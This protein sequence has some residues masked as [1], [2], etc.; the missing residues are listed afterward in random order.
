M[1]AFFEFLSQLDNIFW[2]YIAFIL[3]IILGSIL[4]YQAS[5]FQIKAFP[6]IV[7]LFASLIGS[8]S[9]QA[10]GIHPL[11]AFFASVGGMIGIGNVVG[12]VTAIQI[13]GPGALFWVW[14]AAFI[15][16]LIKY[17]E[18]FLGIKHRIPN[19]RGGYDGGPMYYLPRA[20]KN[21]SIP[22]LIS[23][24]LCIYGV[25]IYQFAVVADTLSSNFEWN[26]Y[27]VIASLL[28][29]VL[30]ASSGGISRIG[31]IC[32][33]IMPAFMITYLGMGFF[34]IFSEIWQLPEILKTVFI[35]AFTGHAA[36]GGFIGSS[37]ILAI[38]HGISRAAYSADIGIGYDSIIQS[39]TS[40]K[41]PERQARLSILGVFIDN[42][43]CTMSIMIVLMSGVWKS[44][45]PIEGSQ[46]IQTA[47]SHY[48]PYMHIFM[49]I[50]LFIVGFSTLIAYFC[51]GMKCAR[52]IS[53][54]YGVGLYMVYGATTLVAFSFLDQM[55][56]LLVM[57]VV[58]A[59]LLIT[60][61]IGIFKL[62][63]E[64]V[65]SHHELPEDIVET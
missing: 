49:P 27:L 5:F 37:V 31:K 44:P 23:L 52:F 14:V 39:E 60:N 33:A 62:R 57:S 56:A 24:F 28:F 3:I 32:T 29:M 17:S 18:I 12:I 54:Q 43:V 42:L 63:H 16:S 34:V 59:I 26:R 50:F 15:G 46:L 4:T 22:L 35:S 36:V 20:F 58:Q 30:Y 51:V 9:N 38:Q 55:H 2:G 61:L 65:F 53:P 10:R 41:G 64:L 40:L 7:K 21:K 19:D 47:L 8:K 45:V 11:K 1:V 6:S 25:E 13:G 48:F